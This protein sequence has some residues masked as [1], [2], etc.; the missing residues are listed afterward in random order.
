M[1][2]PQDQNDGLWPGELD[3][4]VLGGY[5]DRGKLN[6]FESWFLPVHVQNSLVL[7][8]FQ[9]KFHFDR[10]GGPGKLGG[11]QVLEQHLALGAMDMKGIS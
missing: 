2:R 8:D 3:F 11:L 1:R 6:G 5:F 4:P 7:G 9:F 10:E